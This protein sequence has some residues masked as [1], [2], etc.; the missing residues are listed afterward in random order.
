MNFKISSWAIRYPIPI[1]ILFLLLTILGIPTFQTLPINAYPDM[2]FPMVN[3]TVMQTGAL[4][5]E[6]L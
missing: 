4:T 3:I 1:I 5:D 6:L 2:R